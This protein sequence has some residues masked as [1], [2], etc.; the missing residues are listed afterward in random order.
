MAT[1]EQ[2][3]HTQNAPNNFYLSSM[4]TTKIYS[5]PA[6]VISKKKMV[7]KKEIMMD[8]IVNLE[9]EVVVEVG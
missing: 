7:S 1:T 8:I 6:F 4:L 3:T 2:Y 5:S 9:L